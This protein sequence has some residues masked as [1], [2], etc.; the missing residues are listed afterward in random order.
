MTLE[1]KK[2]KYVYIFHFFLFQV[3]PLIPATEMKGRLFVLLAVTSLAFFVSCLLLLTPHNIHLP[4][5]AALN[6]TPSADVNP[7]LPEGE[8]V[9]SSMASCQNVTGPKSLPEQLRW[10]VL[11]LALAIL[12]V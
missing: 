12:Q 9:L 8:P 11:S 1:L 6:S 7:S 4:L 10:D 5:T 2:K 3:C